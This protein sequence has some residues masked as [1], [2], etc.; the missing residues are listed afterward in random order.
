MLTNL[1]INNFR[2]LK[3]LEI[4]PLG[5]VNLLAGKNGAGKTSVLEALWIFSAPDMP[6]LTVRAAGLRGIYPTSA[7]TIFI[8]IFNEFQR[9]HTIEISANAKARSK[10]RELRIYLEERSLSVARPSP[11]DEL[12]QSTQ[13]PTEGQLQI[14][15]TMST[16]MGK[17]SPLELGGSPVQSPLSSEC[18]ALWHFPAPASYRKCNIFRQGMGAR[19]CLL[20]TGKTTLLTSKDL[21]ASSFEG[22]TAK[23]LPLSEQLS[24]S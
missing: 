14:V 20:L 17:N 10:P 15:P 1:R 6:D 5:R 11:S 21:E 16:K 22:E 19:S 4:N 3:G 18:Q 23:Y 12:G 24:P 9:K 2:G 13:P 8:D 7:E